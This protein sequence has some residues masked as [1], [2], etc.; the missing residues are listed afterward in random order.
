M[1]I[2]HTDSSKFNEVFSVIKEKKLHRFDYENELWWDGFNGSQKKQDK[3]SIMF[4]YRC[5]VHSCNL[6]Y[7]SFLRLHKH[8]VTH[9]TR[10]LS[11]CRF[12]SVTWSTLRLLLCILLDK[13]HEIWEMTGIQ[14][15]IILSTYYIFHIHILLLHIGKTW[16]RNEWLW[17]KPS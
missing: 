1:R 3:T 13:C 16:H 7:R 10:C 17:N 4:T 15:C 14:I 5:I 8:F 11:F 2:W 12:E 6:F 9:R